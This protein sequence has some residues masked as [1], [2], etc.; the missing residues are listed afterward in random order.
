MRLSVMKISVLIYYFGLAFHISIIL[1]INFAA[2]LFCWHRLHIAKGFKLNN[3][4]NT[5]SFSD[6]LLGEKRECFKRKKLI[7]QYL[8][9][10]YVAIEYLCYISVKEYCR[11]LSLQMG[12]IDS[13]CACVCERHLVRFVANSHLGL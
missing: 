6:I 5:E 13:L 10:V 9:G 7:H 11:E 3:T 4:F 8:V 2:S 12:Y 1:I